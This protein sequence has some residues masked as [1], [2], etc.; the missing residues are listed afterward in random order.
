MKL[1]K[2]EDQ[3]MGV[4]ILHKSGNKINMKDRGREGPGRARRVGGEKRGEQD[5]V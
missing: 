4:S 3:S 2:K 1:N 5:Q